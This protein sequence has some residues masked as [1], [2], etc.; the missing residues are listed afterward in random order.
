MVMTGKYQPS[1]DK[2]GYG[3][4]HK[5]LRAQIKP[6]VEAGRATCWRCQQPIRKG[7]LWDLGHDDDDRTKYRGPEHANA[8]D[9]PAGGNRS[10]SGRRADTMT[11]PPI[12]T[13]Q[14][15]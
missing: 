1:A 11:Y 10:T 15:W 14:L 7:Q 5:K 6:I 13:S 9:C 4:E 12:D 3:Y 2:R 8:A